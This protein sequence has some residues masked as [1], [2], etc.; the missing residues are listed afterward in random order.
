[1][2]SVMMS[3]YF[4]VI[5]PKLVNLTSSTI[6]CPKDCISPLLVSF[7]ALA[8]LETGTWTFRT[9]KAYQFL[10]FSC[11]ISDLCEQ[12]NLKQPSI[13][14]A[15]PFQAKE[16]PMKISH[17]SIYCLCSDEQKP[18]LFRLRFRR[19]QKLKE[20]AIS[21]HLQS[22]NTVFMLCSLKEKSTRSVLCL[23]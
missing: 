6:A 9:N 18:I 5:F 14:H 7:Y 11:V 12:W 21:A 16:S 1:M 10:I 19:I 23:R 15:S 20:M 8:S 4:C 22:L 17:G 3:H 2:K 13:Y